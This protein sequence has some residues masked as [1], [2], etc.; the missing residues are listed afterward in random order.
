MHMTM[1]YIKQTAFVFFAV[2]FFSVAAVPTMAHAQTYEQ[3]RQQLIAEIY[4][5]LAEL[6]RVEG[7]TV[8]YYQPGYRYGYVP[9]TSYPPARVL[10]AS[11]GSAQVRVET[12]SAIDVDWDEASVYGNVDLRS[13]RYADVWFVYGE[14]DDNLTEQSRMGRIDRNDH[15]T[16]RADLE[17][18]DE[19][20]RYYYRAVAR[21]PQGRVDYG[22]I[23]SF[24]TDDRNFSRDDDQ[25]DVTTG[26]A[27][28]IDDDSA[29][30]DGEVD[31]NDATDG[32]VFFAYGEDEDQIR[33]IDRDY[34][35]YRDIDE[36]GD[37]L[38]LVLVDSRF[39]GRGD[40]D[41]QVYG[42]DD[43]TEYYFTLCVE[44]EDEDGDETIICG[45]VNDFETDRD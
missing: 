20:E 12:L 7:Q 27:Y 31:M 33:D 36:D 3:T 29:E 35:E 25:P 13:A 21:D 5:L 40:F 32:L 24:T 15:R 42:L 10:G 43:D 4:R 30:F 34:D 18:L 14:N 39:D 2:L 8:F 23:R 17:D 26:R 22:N 11:S 37:D 9:T 16:F 45:T 44:F 6:A 38:Q 28:N 19:D 1:Q 41:A